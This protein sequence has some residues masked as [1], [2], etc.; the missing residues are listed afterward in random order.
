VLID[1]SSPGIGDGAYFPTLGWTYS[2]LVVR[3]T[4]RG[5]SH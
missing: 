1:F 5:R 3:M 2:N 4:P